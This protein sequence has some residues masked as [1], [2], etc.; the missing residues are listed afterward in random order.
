M[1][2][3]PEVLEALK[4]CYDPEIPVDIVNLGLVYEVKLEPAPADPAKQDVTVEM[5]MTSPMCPS[6]TFITEQVRQRVQRMDGVNLA[7]VVLVWQPPWGPERISAE[8]K[9]KLGIDV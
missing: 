9:Q 4:E 8:A 5:T 7:A 3:Q 6:H 1:P 2:T